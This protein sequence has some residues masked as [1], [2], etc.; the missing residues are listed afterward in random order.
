MKSIAHIAGLGLITLMAFKSIRQH[1]VATGFPA[2]DTEAH[3]GGR[4]LWPEN[5]I[6]A[7]KGAVDLGVTTLEMDTHVTADGKVVLSHDDYLNP[8][9]TLSPDGKEFAQQEAEQ[10]I[11]YKMK[12]ADLRK[13]DVGSKFYSKFP[14]QE[15]I[16]SHIPLL[17]DVIDSVQQYIKVSGKKQPFYNIETKCDVAGDNKFNPEPEQFVKLLMDVVVRKEILPYVVIQSFDVR[18]IQ[19]IH[20]KYPEVH[21][22]YLVDDNHGLKTFEKSMAFL[23][24]KPYIYSPAYKMVDA[25]LVQKCHDQ[26]I[27]IIPWTVNSKKE[28]TSL[29]TLKVDGIISDYPDLLVK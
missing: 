17:A 23:G 12:Y 3:R 24:F 5:T 2:F 27:K 7:M 6:L 21:V 4:G 29:K 1:S 14:K 20:K 16:K 11:L 9:F 15:K 8:Q 13:Y 19:L 18:T 10:L 28:I 25:A 22:S 26:G